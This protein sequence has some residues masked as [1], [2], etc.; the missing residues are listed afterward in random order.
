MAGAQKFA[1]LVKQKSGGKMIVNV[2]E[3][4][5]L[6]NDVSA[7]SSMLGGTLDF[8][9]MSVGTLA[10]YNKQFSVFDFPYMFNNEKEVDAVLDSP[11]GAKVLGKLP[12]KGFIGLAYAEL[13]F[14][15]MHNSKRPVNTLADLQGLKIRVY[16]GA[17]L[18]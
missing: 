17:D 10:S 9:L 13:G 3:G 12:E 15:H 7:L 2:Y 14:R 1:D 5:A 11:V 18:S 8:S 16:P 4:G 6:G